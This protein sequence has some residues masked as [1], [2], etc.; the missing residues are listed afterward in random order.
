MKKYLVFLT[1]IALLTV[2][3]SAQIINYGKTLPPQSYGIGIAPVYNLGNAFHMPDGEFSLMIF[4]GYSLKYNLDLG[5]KYAFFQNIAD[6]LSIDIQ[7]LFRETRKNYFNIIAG[8][9]K[10]TQ[11]TEDGVL[12]P[13]SSKWTQFG[14]NGTFTFTYA[15]KFA[16]N[17]STGLKI[18]ADVY[19][20]FEIRGWIPFNFGFYPGK[21]SFV[22]FEYDLPVTEFSWDIFSLGINLVIR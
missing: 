16:L 7:Y 22:F 1:L 21:Y 14:I 17:L 2:S 13:G 5:L 9:H 15:P 19:K 20:R 11:Y 18:E 3:T 6:Y 10:W 12:M 8:I 4:G